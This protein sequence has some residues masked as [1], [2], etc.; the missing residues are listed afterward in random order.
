MDTNLGGLNL[1]LK[2]KTISQLDR[3]SSILVWTSAD[4]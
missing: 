1:T 4:V 2:L 3:K